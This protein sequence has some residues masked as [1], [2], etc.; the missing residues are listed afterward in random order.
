MSG[1]LSGTRVVDLTS[2]VMG[3]YATQILADYGADVVKVES[4]DGD[5]MRLAGPMRHPRMGHLFLN[6]NRN[7]RSVVIDLK[8]E[9]GRAVLLEL[10]RN[11]DALVYN[12]RPQAMARLGL[13]YEDVCAVNPGIIYVGAFGFS[14]RGPY[15]ARPAYDDLIQGMSGIPWLVEAAGADEPRYAPVILADRMVGLQLAVAI[16]SALLHRARTGRGQRVDVPMYEGLVSVVLGEHLGGRMFHPPE[17]PAG[18]QRSLSRNRRPY[19]TLDGHVCVMIYTDKH[20]R[21]FFEAIG[22][23]EMFESDSRFSTHGER[24]RCVDEVYGFL[25]EVIAT[26]S[27]DE[28]LELFD[29][30]DIPAARMYSMEDILADEHLSAIDFFQCRSH[31]TEGPITMVA[32]PTEWSDSP[33]GPIR[34]A[35]GLGD[36]TVEVLSEA[37]YTAE[38]IERLL[39][40]GAIRQS[41]R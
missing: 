21:R 2:V 39:S 19:R 30:A 16:T 6:T 27:T 23:S 4:P 31:P 18:Y 38:D 36:D 1:P 12:I 35:P 7:K 9:E 41:S 11:A 15:A 32:V 10:A 17:G 13:S 25:A 37:G 14:Q 3:P 26:R 22:K 29:L 33:P 34:H 40:Q 5:V 20:W 28:W 8:H 24:T